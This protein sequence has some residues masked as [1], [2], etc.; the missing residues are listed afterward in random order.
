MISG[1]GDARKRSR[2]DQIELGLDISN[3]VS[4][5]GLTLSGPE[6]TARTL[7]SAQ[8]MLSGKSSTLTDMPLGPRSKFACLRCRKRKT[9]CSGEFPCRSCS[10]TGADCKYPRKPKWIKVY[11][12]EIEEY[13]N[14]VESLEKE[15]RRLKGSNNR[16]LAGDEGINSPTGESGLNLSSDFKLG[17]SN[18]SK[19]NLSNN[20][21]LGLSIGVSKLNLSVWLGCAS[22]E[23]ICWNLK[24]FTVR[25]SNPSKDL[26]ISPDFSSFREER[27]YDFI[28]EKQSNHQLIEEVDVREIL[29]DLTFSELELLFD[30]VVTFIN[31]GYL[32]V[33]PFEF[34]EH[35][36]QYFDENGFK[37]D[38]LNFQ[39]SSN[40]FFLKLVTI[41]AL[42]KIYS[43]DSNLGIQ[44]QRLEEVPGL[45][46]FKL[47]IKYLPSP[48]ELM[49]LSKSSVNE[50]FEI[51]ELFGLI[52][53]YLRI[54][55]KKNAA[56]MFTL[57]AL[58]M[59][60]A[61]NLH[62]NR[63]L[64]SVEINSKPTHYINRIWWGTF[65]L[66]RFYSSRIGQPLLLQLEDITTC[67][68]AEATTPPTSRY[69]FSN[70]VSM[71]FYILLAK[72]ADRITN[73]IYCFKLPF[74]NKQYL[75]SI[76]SIMEMLVDWANNIPPFLRLELSGQVYDGNDRLTNTLHLNY[77]H[78]IYLTCI[79][80]L[81]NFV[82]VK[83]INFDKSKLTTLRPLYLTEL[84]KNLSNLVLTIINASQLTMNIFMSLYKR[85]FVSAFGFTDLDYL[86]SSAL[87]FLICLI[88]KIDNSKEKCHSYQEYLEVS[89]NLIHE[90]KVMGNE[91]ARGKLDQLIDLMESLTDLLQELGYTDLLSKL[92]R[93]GENESLLDKI[94]EK[95]T[96]DKLAYQR[97]VSPD[98]K[99]EPMDTLVEQQ[100]DLANLNDAMKDQFL[101]GFEVGKGIVDVTFLT[102]NE[103]VGD[104]DMDPYNPLNAFNI[105][106]EDI[107]FMDQIIRDFN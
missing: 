97:S 75:Q 53:V 84:P 27:K 64:R 3:P 50:T 57:N 45:N 16:V 7:P 20:P 98:L 25:S 107:L 69:D 62:K 96:M 78:H 83:I 48:F 79:P 28:L 73:E 76:L 59:C 100:G 24:Q 40:Y 23:L 51:I 5:P 90:M 77:L 36:K 70:D 91:I 21:K 104:I 11:D 39:R 87:V 6:T 105:T 30:N 71:K 60:I 47:V 42:G 37:F 63:Q 82:K 89:M 41:L 10:S 44:T 35:S 9:K 22:S 95:F 81:V 26:L 72:I 32:T 17:S 80:I 33:D 15:L 94:S 55:D 38:K 103:I 49:S 52:A 92:H 99:P 56:V 61:L 18:E 43:K 66:N 14:K 101:D 1:N 2:K 68:I 88:L 31:S 29:K 12:T 8:S 67:D 86:T 13:Q 106:E 102:K 4:F 34:I 19:L 46:Y 54:L 58:Q 85:R 93:Y 65:C 74:N